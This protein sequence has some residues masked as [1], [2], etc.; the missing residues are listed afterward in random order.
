MAFWTRAGEVVFGEFTSLFVGLMTPALFSLFQMK[1]TS[2]TR[3]KSIR[4]LESPLRFSEAAHS[5]IGGC[6]NPLLIVFEGGTGAGKSTRLNHLI[7]GRM[8]RNLGPF[9]VR[10]GGH[11]VTTGFDT[12]GIVPLSTFCRTFNI[13]N[14]AREE[15]NLFFVDS[16]GTGNAFGVD[17]NLG[18]A[19]AALSSVATIRVAVSQSRFRADSIEGIA[20]TL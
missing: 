9:K 2:E 1:G 4:N 12:W 7:N 5:Q 3:R 6:K 14:P 20:A 10:A 13:P 8:G 19:L 17:P 16:E 11:G 15:V 18:K